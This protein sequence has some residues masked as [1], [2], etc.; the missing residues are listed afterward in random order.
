METQHSQAAT[1]L[2]RRV[3]VEAE[4]IWTDVIR[5]SREQLGGRLANGEAFQYHLPG[6]N[7]HVY[8]RISQGLSTRDEHGADE[9]QARRC[10]SPAI[11]GFESGTSSSMASSRS[12]V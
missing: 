5:P 7:L 3:K 2:P 6:A 1:P 10:P 9:L 11:V 12:G 4:G 8:E